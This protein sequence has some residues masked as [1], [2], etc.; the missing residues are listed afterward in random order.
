MDRLFKRGVSK[1]SEMPALEDMSEMPP[2]I[3][4][5]VEEEATS[6]SGEESSIVVETTEGM[7]E[8]QSDP[9]PQV[10]APRLKRL[11]T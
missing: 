10:P 11:R 3:D 6:K 1:I 9:A 8:E 7:R 4:T 5:S 2:L